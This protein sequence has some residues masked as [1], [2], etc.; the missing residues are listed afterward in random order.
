MAHRICRHPGSLRVFLG[1]LKAPLVILDGVE[2]AKHIHLR[3]PKAWM[4]CNLRIDLAHAGEGLKG[5]RDVCVHARSRSRVDPHTLHYH[6]LRQFPWAGHNLQKRRVNAST[7]IHSD[8]Q[9]IGKKDPRTRL[10]DPI[11]A[12][13]NEIHGEDS[14]RDQAW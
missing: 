8:S 7:L 11:L 2:Y 1:R 14:N 4:L 10:S 13:E 6:R 12:R 9:L 5:E 3:P